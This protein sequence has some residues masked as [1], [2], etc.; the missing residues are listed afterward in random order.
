MIIEQLPI[1]NLKGMY[2]LLFE[3]IRVTNVQVLDGEINS[4]PNELNTFWSRLKF[5]MNIPSISEE[6]EACF[7]I[8]NHNNFQ[9]KISIVSKI[10]LKKF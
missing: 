7:K 10:F 8:L 3:G 9:Y 1:F 5:F 6:T 2:P 4:V